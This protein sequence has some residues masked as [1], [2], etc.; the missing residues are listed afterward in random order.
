MGKLSG[1][2]VTPLYLKRS[3]VQASKRGLLRKQDFQTFQIDSYLKRAISSLLF[4][5]FSVFSNK[6]QFLQKIN[7]KNSHPVYG[8]GIRTHDLLN[9]SRLP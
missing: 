1:N 9:M 6:L 2:L 4:R 7:V 8:A 5:L 3:V